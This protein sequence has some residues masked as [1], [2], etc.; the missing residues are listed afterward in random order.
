MVLD[1]N[2]QVYPKAAYS[3]S[4]YEA[5]KRLLHMADDDFCPV[6]LR[7]GT[8]HGFSARMRYDLAVNTFVKDA[9]SK[10]VLTLH[11]GGEMWRLV[12]DIRYAAR[13]YIAALEADEDKIRGQIFNVSYRNVRI[14]ELALKVRETVREIG[15]NVDI[16]ADYS[17]RAVRRYRIS[18]RKIKDILVWEAVLTIEESVRDLVEKVE[19]YNYMD[20]DNPKYYNIRWMKLLEE[21]EETTSRLGGK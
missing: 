12:V 14:W 18:G 1:E 19:E 20:F 7:K 15:I 10:G 9:V 17:Y 8:I 3:T 11:Y 4:K 13:A 2:S 6:I 21:A 16:K 5:E